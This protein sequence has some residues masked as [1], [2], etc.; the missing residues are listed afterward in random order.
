MDGKSLDIA[1]DKLESIKEILPEAFSEGKLDIEK[2][3]LALGEDIAIQDERYVLN[4][5]GK[6][7]AFRALQTPTTATLAP[8]REESINF[9]ETENIFIEGENLE[10]LKVLQKAYYGKVKMIYIDPPYNTGSDSFVYP[11]KFSESREDYLKRIQAKD[12]EGNL[13]REG[14]FRSNSKDS[15]HYHSNWLSMMYPRLFLARNLLREDGV[16]FISID[17]NEV[18]NLR[19]LMNSVF[20]EEN[21]LGIIVWKN[22]TDNNPS[23]VAV[24]HEYLC[25]FAK[26]AN[27][28]SPIW[29]SPVSDA[30]STLIEI[31]KELAAKYKT[32]DELQAAYSTWFRQNKAYL[33]ALDRY[34]YIDFDGVYTGSQSV[35]NPG[36]EGYRYDVIHPETGKPCKQPLMGYRFPESTMRQMLEDGVILF[37]S[38]ENK[39]IEIKVYAKDYADKLSSL[40]QLD[41]RLGAYDLKGLFGGRSGIFNNPKPVQMLNDLFPFVL[42]AGDLVLDF[43]SGS[44]STAHAIFELNGATKRDASFILVQYPEEFD[45]KNSKH[46]PAIQF[47]ESHN[48][49]STIAEVGKERIRRAIHKIKEENPMF[50]EQGQ[51]LGFKVLKLKHSNFKLWRGDGIDNEE[52][53]GE[54]LEMLTDPVMQEAQEEN[55][56]TE[57]LLKSGYML[58]SPIK[59]K[60]AGDSHYWWVAGKEGANLAVAL[61]SLSKELIAEII[62]AQPQKLICLDRLFESD[63]LK[64]NTQLQ[65]KDA[66]I[67]FHSI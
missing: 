16:I 26:N 39:I 23:R 58:T 41:G 60:P 55:M 5:A 3:R 49:S 29:K 25:V 37:G 14:Q 12:E 21:F 63:Q 65:C 28:C 46:K 8:A 17:D 47:C 6:G 18:H 27:V 11:D 24:E 34:K 64:T 1:Q 32:L 15:G 30:K 67:V 31:G 13:L 54:Q 42:E 36:K 62:K 44:A 7:D 9:D 40:L 56:L 51:D 43:F 66:G 19:L 10:V 38:N 48:L 61:Y 4:W 50:A 52:E 53:L 45:N 2:L 57:L 22:V 33:G 20:G 35:H 59:K